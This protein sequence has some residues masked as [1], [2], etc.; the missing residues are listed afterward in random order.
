MQAHLTNQ[1][2]SAIEAVIAK[3]HPVIVAWS[4][5]KDSSVV[6]N[7]VLSAARAQKERAKI[8]PII[9][10][11]ADTGI[12]NPEIARY[13]QKEL[14]KIKAYGKACGLELVVQVS[15]PQLNSRWAVRVIGGRG[16]PVFPSSGGTG[17]GNRDCT[18]D[19]KVLPMQRL[20]KQILSG[21]ARSE[22]PAVTVIGTRFEESAGRAQRMQNRGETDTAPW[23]G[24]ND[25]L[26]LSPI[27]RWDTEDVWAYISNCMDGLTEAYSDFKQTFKL[28]AEAS[29]SS[30][31]I[32][33]DIAFGTQKSRSSGCGARFGCMLCT[34]TN[35]KSMENMLAIDEYAYMREAHEL[36]QFI[37]KTQYDLDRRLWV[38]R[39][40]NEYGY[41]AIRPDVYSPAMLLELL[42]YAL[43]ID[44]VEKQRASAAQIEPRFE[45][46]GAKELIAIDAMWSLQGYHRPF[47]ALREYRDIYLGGRRYPVPN[48]KHFA[49]VPICEARYYHVGP[50]WD[51]QVKR[52][53]GFRD[54]VIEAFGGAGC[55]GKKELKDGRVVLDTQAEGPFSVDEEGAIFALTLDLD[56]LLDRVAC[57]CHSHT[58]GYPHHVSSG[59]LI[60][61]KGKESVIDKIMRR[62]AFKERHG[63][64]GQSYNLAALLAKSVSRVEMEQGIRRAQLKAVPPRPMV[65]LTLPGFDIYQEKAA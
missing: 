19:Y 63:L 7:L 2:T 30:C 47:A 10:T 5:G 34:A 57:D 22:M 14:L 3:G 42:R 12:E 31:A 23:V 35:D 26:Y 15:R 51:E 32:E 4:G 1:A 37:I 56:Y 50:D 55:M 8:V 62:T 64:A 43:T 54:P 61:A 6:L 13:A 46:I 21:L 24:A 29:G 58:Y 16:L 44:V 60:P 36:Q 53:S 33:A 9:I 65:Q 28:Y 38:G 59:Y 18:L 40:I 27:A 20:R 17:G 11:H 48:I 25:E 39:S 52:F 49:R 45:L 41:I